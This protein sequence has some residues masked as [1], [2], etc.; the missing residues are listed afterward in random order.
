MKDKRQKVSQKVE[1]L[2]TQC[3]GLEFMG[4]GLQSPWVGGSPF[5]KRYIIKFH[6]IHLLLYPIVVTQTPA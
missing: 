4:S 3:R 1:R 5:C 6:C 2:N